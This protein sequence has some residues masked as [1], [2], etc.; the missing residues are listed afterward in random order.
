M[1]QKNTNNYL[2]VKLEA[3]LEKKSDGGEG[4]PGSRAVEGL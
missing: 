2:K 3:D 4:G 1:D